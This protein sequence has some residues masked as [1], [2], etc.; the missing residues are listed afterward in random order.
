MN[1]DSADFAVVCSLRK[2]ITSLLLTGNQTLAGPLVETKYKSKKLEKYKVKCL[3]SHSI[4]WR[5][6]K[7]KNQ[8]LEQV[9]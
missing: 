7:V 9:G 6:V 4:T 3:S 2:K 1:L 5:K 8:T